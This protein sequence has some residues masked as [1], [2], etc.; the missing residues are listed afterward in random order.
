LICSAELDEFVN[1]PRI[2]QA[3]LAGFLAQERL[4]LSQQK[5]SGPQSEK[6]DVKLPIAA[7]I[8]QLLPI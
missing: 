5:E 4:M 8:L 2:F 1:F 6:I 3:L 7:G